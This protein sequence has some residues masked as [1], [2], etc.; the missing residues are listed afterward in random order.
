MKKAH[1]LMLIA[2]F[3]TLT[4]GSFIWF[5]ATWDSAKEQPIGQLAPA[6]IERA[7]T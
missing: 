5:I 7:T 2:A 3:I 4:L 1:I 6:P